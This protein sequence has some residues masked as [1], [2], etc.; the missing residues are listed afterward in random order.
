[1]IEPQR[2]LSLFWKKRRPQT[3]I[4]PVSQHPIAFLSYARFDDQHE[5]GRMSEF[6]QYFSGEVQLQTGSKFRIFQDSKDIAWGEQWQHRIDQ[7]LDLV[8]FLIPM[9]TP[10]FFSSEAAATNWNVFS[11]A[12]SS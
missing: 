9:I 1:L 4:N 5:N 7:S 11:I 8:T 2:L 6:C 3:N 10:S 12:K